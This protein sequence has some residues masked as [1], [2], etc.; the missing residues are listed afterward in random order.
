MAKGLA[1]VTGSSTFV[2]KFL[3]DG[4]FQVGVDVPASSSFSGSLVLDLV[5]EQ[6]DGLFLRS[7]ANNS[8][9][10]NQISASEVVVVPFSTVTGTNAQ[11]VFEEIRATIAAAASGSGSFGVS[12]GGNTEVIQADGVSTVT[13]EGT[14]EN[15]TSSYASAT[16]TFTLALTDDVRIV[17]DLDVGGDLDVTG[18]AV[19]AGNLTVNGTAS[20]IN[21]NNLFVE[22]PLILLASGNAGTSLDIGLIMQRGGANNRGFI[23]DESGDE[24]AV[25]DTTESGIVSGNV[26]IADYV[27]LHAGALIA[28]DDLTVGGDAKVTGDLEVTGSSRLIDVTASAGVLVTAGGIKVTG[29]VLL[30]DNSITNAEL[31]NSTYN[32]TPGT[33][34]TG[35]GSTELGTSVGLA[36]DFG[37]GSGQ[38]SYG[39]GVLQI[40]GSTNEVIVNGGLTAA[41]PLGTGSTLTIG[42]P[43]DVTITNNLNVGGILSVTG[44]TYLG[45][46]ATDIIEVQG[47]FRIPVFTS[48][49]IPAAFS[50]SPELYHG[51]SFYLTGSGLPNGDFF[52]TANKWYHNEGGMWH[53]SFFS[54]S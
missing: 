15:I 2:H 41:V 53:K 26:T 4:T 12:D 18:N 9:S 34:L 22:D 27:P 43:D 31:V 13:W 17:N 49:Q 8:A 36:V 25:I 35:G 29:S 40:T 6:G 23:F 42:L 33:G 54:N 1:V 48:G 50:S 16:N 37:T 10:W 24:F 5:G 46:A 3:E 39:D 44:S 19:I 45:D 30:P 52:R 11:D 7:D 32:I 20:F 28:D 38:V 47:Q 21:T 14:A 51:Y